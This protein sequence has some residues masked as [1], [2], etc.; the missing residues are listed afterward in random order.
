MKKLTFLFLFL[1]VF[2]NAQNIEITYSVEENCD[3]GIMSTKMDYVLKMTAEKSVFYNLDT[4]HTQFKYSDFVDEIKPYG[5]YERAKLSDN[6]YKPIKKDFFYKSFIEDVIVFR[7]QER[8]RFLI[9]KENL[10]SLFNWN[11]DS[12]ETKEIMGFTCQKA[13]AEFRGRKYE[14]YFTSELGNYGGPW[15]FDGL[16]GVILAVKSVDDYFVLQ[17]KEIKKNRVDFKIDSRNMENIETISWEEFVS[18]KE[19][20]LKKMFKKLKSLSA[21]GETGKIQ[22]KD[23]LEDLGI[24]TMSF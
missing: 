10:T 8:G 9:I 22:L 6:H 15:K 14:A 23:Q 21:P 20:Y 13:T 2:M 4:T 17:A 3:E 5:D 18:M 12:K 19:E 7:K 16:P 11:I 1:G 24:K